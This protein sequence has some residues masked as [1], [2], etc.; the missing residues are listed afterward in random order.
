MA[1]AEATAIASAYASA[2]G[3]AADCNRCQTSASFV[4]EQIEIILL[5]A[6]A[7]AEVRLIAAAQPGVPVTVAFSNFVADV[8]QASVVAFAEV[9]TPI[10]SPLRACHVNLWP[11]NHLRV[12][13]ALC[14]VPVWECA[15]P[16]ANA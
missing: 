2:L 15:R 12:C 1:V 9:Y 4:A 3:S 5:R 13:M 10:S 14:G 7:A 11:A 8:E 16:N 6:V